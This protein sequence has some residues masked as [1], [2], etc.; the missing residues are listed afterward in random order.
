MWR[1]LSF[2]MLVSLLFVSQ[3]TNTLAFSNCGI[4]E[5]IGT[6]QVAGWCTSS[7][8]GYYDQCYWYCQWYAEYTEAS[9]CWVE[10]HQCEEVSEPPPGAVFSCSCLCW[11]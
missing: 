11:Y 8:D 10:N 4:D 7:C 9:A 3:G 5:G 6:T 1:N 2:V